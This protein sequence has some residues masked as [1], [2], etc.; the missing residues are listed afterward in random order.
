MKDA[1]VELVRCQ[2]I[3]RSIMHGLAEGGASRQVVAATACALVRLATRP[4][5]A[6]I[7]ME[8]KI[9]AVASE[10]LGEGT[11]IG[12]LVSTLRKGGFGELASAASLNHKGRTRAA[13]P[14]E[15]LDVRIRSALRSRVGVTVVDEK[16]DEVEDEYTNGN[17]VPEVQVAMRKAASKSVA[18]I[19]SSL[20]AHAT[21]TRVRDPRP[22]RHPPLQAGIP[23]GRLAADRTGGDDPL[24]HDTLHSLPVGPLHGDGV[25][26]EATDDEDHGGRLATDR[27]GGDDPYVDDALHT[28]SGGPLA[29]Q[30]TTPAPPPP[31]PSIP[32][33]GWKGAWPAAERR[34]ME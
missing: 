30:P 28:S 22:P 13:H 8:E 27:T 16:L 19:L 11:G 24:T 32:P 1:D 2:S 18:D 26:D 9:K 25:V 33:P 21:R 17:V 7:T 34:Q 10:E 4:D 31:P 6:C 15:R 3:A 12:L 5:T 20:D 29:Y 23:V 14:A